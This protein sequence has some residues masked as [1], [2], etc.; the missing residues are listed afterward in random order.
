MRPRISLRWL[1][2]V[3]AIF[4]IA[5]YFVFARPTVIAQRFAAAAS[6]QDLRQLTELVS[7]D[8]DLGFHVFREF[9]EVKPTRVSMRA[10]VQPLTWNDVASFRRRIEFTVIYKFANDPDSYGKETV[11]AIARRT[12]VEICY[13]VPYY[14]H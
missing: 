9:W 8:D 3:F 6:S 12:S 14:V 11:P 1:L 2:I 10:V 7:N 4:G 5:F 13:N